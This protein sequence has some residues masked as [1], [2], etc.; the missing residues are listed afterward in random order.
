MI[1]LLSLESAQMQ[2]ELEHFKYIIKQEIPM[3]S[4]D[5]DISPNAMR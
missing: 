1:L 4:H 5:L 2:I 3:I